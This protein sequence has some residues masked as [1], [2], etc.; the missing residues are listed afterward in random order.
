M[1]RSD[2]SIS[3]ACRSSTALL[4]GTEERE[5]K[6]GAGHVPSTALPGPACN[7]AIAAD[8]DRLVPALRF[9]KPNDE[10]LIRAKDGV[11]YRYVIKQT[12]IVS[13]S[14]VAVLRQTLDP[15]LT[16]ITCYPSFYRG[17][18]PKRF[19]VHAEGEVLRASS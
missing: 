11:S 16:L 7:L 14:D 3:L 15:E 13:P 2:R 12:E 4:E 10:V 6:R 8:R 1:P 18:A 19:M 17:H 9:I 5:L